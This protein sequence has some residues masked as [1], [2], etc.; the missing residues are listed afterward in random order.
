VSGRASVSSRDRP[1]GRVRRSGR[2]PRRDRAQPQRPPGRVWPASAGQRPG[3]G[4]AAERWLVATTTSRQIKEERLDLQEDRTRS[5]SPLRPHRRFDPPLGHLLRPPA[6]P[7]F[8]RPDHVRP[9]RRCRVFL[10]FLLLVWLQ[11]LS[12]ACCSSPLP[13]RWP[14]SLHTWAGPQF[15]WGVEEGGPARSGGPPSSPSPGV[16]PNSGQRWGSGLLIS[17]DQ[18]IEINR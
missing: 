6:A 18:P 11:L 13:H 2:S 17:W 3:S 15:Y 10:S 1:L 7:P 4:D 16:E 14:R 12:V 8:S 5:T 9:I